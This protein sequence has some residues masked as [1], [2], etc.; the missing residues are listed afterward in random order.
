M[1][2]CWRCWRWRFARPGLSARGLAGAAPRGIGGAR[3]SK[4]RTANISASRAAGDILDA[5]GNL[6]AT[7]IF[8]KTVCA[9]PVLIGNR[10]AEV[11][12][13]LAPAVADETRRELYQRLLPRLRQNDNGETVT[14]RYVVLKHK[15]PG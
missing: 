6:L 3:R 7:S 4:T 13:M 15:V 2:L 11:A 1:L 8:V 14:N 9:D 5:Q 12:R 10:Q